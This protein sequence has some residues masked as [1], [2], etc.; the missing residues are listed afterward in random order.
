MTGNGLE[1]AREAVNRICELA[2]EGRPESLEASVALLEDSAG[3]LAPFAA[4]LEPEL[5]RLGL[6]AGQAAAFYARCLPP[7][8]TAPC[9]TA[10]GGAG[11]A[12]AAGQVHLE[13]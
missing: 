6:L 7:V 11:V 4:E 2:G 8:G 1:Q 10:R 13:G 9:Y 12:P 3:E 5:G